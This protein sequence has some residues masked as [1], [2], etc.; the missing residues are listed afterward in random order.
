[1][2]RYILRPLFFSMQPENAHD[3]MRAGGRVANCAPVSRI[4]RSH[5]NVVDPRLQVQVAGLSFSNPIGLAAGLDKNA[6][7]LGLWNGL[8]FGHIELGTVTAK[9]QPG[10]PK[11]RIFRL[12]ADGALVNRMGFPSEGADYLAETLRRIRAGNLALPAL[13]INI[14]K[15]K[16]TEIADAVADYAYSFKKLVPYVDYVTVNVSSPNT[17][18]LRQ[19]QER[20][21]LQGLLSEL[22]S[23]NSQ[24]KPIFVKVAPD[25]T[26]EALDEVIECCLASKM[27]GIIA[28]NTTLGREGLSTS[29][30]EA[31]GLSGVP[32]FRRSLE[33]VRFLGSRLASLPAGR[34]SLV[35]VGG[36]RS[37]Q[38]V[39][40]ML[41]AGAQMVQLYT[42]LIYEG[43]GLVK[44]LNTGLVAFMDKHG[45]RSLQEATQV[46]A[47]GL[48]AA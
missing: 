35:G 9:A 12:A 6:E 43:P 19:L 16:L 25:L 24:G 41:A 32:L 31:G 33:V 45:C 13:G 28:T 48:K 23:L 18:G 20:E 38:D 37:Y 17:P 44:S 21:R 30:D 27:A 1:M 7:L 46:W 29:I 5:Y 42:A 14:G 47:S 22:Q 8:G 11:P 10:N 4:L 39:L 3:L 26:L 15:S 34:L 2:Y 36:I 40:S